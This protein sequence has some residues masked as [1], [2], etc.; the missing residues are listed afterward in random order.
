MHTH[1]MGRQ[2]VAGGCAREDRC[3]AGGRKPRV[4]LGKRCVW[5][6][7]FFERNRRRH[8]RRRMGQRAAGGGWNQ[9]L[10]RV[11]G[12]VL[13]HSGRADGKAGLTPGVHQWPVQVLSASEGRVG[14]RPT[15]TSGAAPV[16]PIAGCHPPALPGSS[17][18]D[19]LTTRTLFSL[20]CFFRKT[21][22][23][24]VQPFDPA[25]ILQ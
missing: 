20:T 3:C 15:N 14:L 23:C 17:V 24:S 9:R 25:W 2:G 22:P 18:Q 19:K 1:G 6:Q 21:N 11:D 16:K 7:S 12:S 5:L 13:R 8:R 10:V 4:L